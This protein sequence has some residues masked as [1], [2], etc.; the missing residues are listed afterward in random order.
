MA[1]QSGKTADFSFNSV[2]IEDE[3]SKRDYFKDQLY[4][5]IYDDYNLPFQKLKESYN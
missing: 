5:E 1:R 3:L 4:P 2:A